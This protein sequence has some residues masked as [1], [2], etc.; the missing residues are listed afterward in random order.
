M[1]TEQVRVGILVGGEPAPGINSTVSSAT[2]ESVNSGLE[3]IGIYDGFHH[4]M[5]GRTDMERPLR[6]PDVSRIHCEWG[7]MLRISRANPT[8]GPDLLEQTVKALMEL[9]IAHLVTIGDADTAF[10]AFERWPRR[11]RAP[12]EL[13]RPQGQ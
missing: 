9:G 2:I 11:R 10:A 1:S 7:S 4:I 3:V 8:R 13:P 5:D 12:S 6:I